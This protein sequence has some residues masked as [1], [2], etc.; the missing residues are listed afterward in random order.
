MEIIK[1]ASQFLEPLQ[2]KDILKGHSPKI[3]KT[4]ISSHGSRRAFSLRFYVFGELSLTKCHF[5]FYTSDKF[6]P[7]TSHSG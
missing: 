1:D 7:V 3:T 2:V 5:I 6:P 4:R